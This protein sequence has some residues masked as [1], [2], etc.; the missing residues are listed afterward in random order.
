MAVAKSCHPPNADDRVPASNQRDEQ[1]LKLT[2]ALFARLKHLH[3]LTK[4]SLRLVKGVAWG[5]ALRGLPRAA[6]TAALEARLESQRLR[7]TPRQL[8]LINAALEIDA[9]S[10]EAPSLSPTVPGTRRQALGGIA[11]RLAALVEL[12]EG[13][14]GIG[15]PQAESV[16]VCDDGAAVELLVRGSPS[17]ERVMQ[18][19]PRSVALWNA[20]ALRPIRGIGAAEELPGGSIAAIRPEEP[21]AEVGRRI[22]QRLLEQLLSRL[23]GL[24]YLEDPEYVHEMRVAIRRLRAAIRVFRKAFADGLQR[25]R[26]ELRKLADALGEA[27]D[28]DVFLAFLEAYAAKGAKGE[29]RLLAGLI[30]SERRQRR[31]Q[32]RRL[33]QLCRAAEYQAY[34]GQLYERLRTPAGIDGGV[35]VTRKGKTKAVAGLAGKALSRG[36]EEVVSYGPRLTALPPARQHDL[37]IACKKLRYAAEFLADLYPPALAGLIEAMTGLQE[38]LGESHDADV[39]EERLTAYFHK[40]FAKP[41]DKAQQAFRTLRSHLKRRKRKDLAKAAGLWKALRAPG[42][43]RALKKLVQAPVAG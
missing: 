1:L 41:G 20:F 29:Q 37:R 43:L 5:W 16:A 26:D 13:L 18:R 3:G 34:L 33:L 4:T 12:A 15:D 8:K 30:R 2:L 21:M 24:A 25:D 39:Y 35:A 9:D 11:L 38:H 36:L 40:R 28:G 19:G 42:R 31:T 7:L 32:A 14:A 6:R 10:L 22:L 27:R 17:A 23:Y